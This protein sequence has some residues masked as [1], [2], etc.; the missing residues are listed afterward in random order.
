MFAWLFDFAHL[1]TLNSIAEEMESRGYL[2][3]VF[4]RATGIK[5]GILIPAALFGIGHIPINIFIYRSSAATTLSN[6][7]G[8]TIFGI[9]ASYLFTITGNI[10]APISLHSV[11]N[12]IQLSSPLQIDI[13]NG[14]PLMNYVLM[15]VANVIIFFIILGLL[16]LLHKRKPKWLMK[17]E[18]LESALDWQL[19]K[20]VGTTVSA[21]SESRIV[22][23]AEDSLHGTWT[24]FR[25][26]AEGSGC[27]LL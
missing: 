14:A 25:G 12:V 7:A 19:S 3:T 20:G 4:S 26:Y 23:G 21:R 6:V 1:L 16:T 24:G 15:E 8:A 11:W 17:G 9:V 5:R 22:R 10:L 18:E 2:Q 27:H 13:A